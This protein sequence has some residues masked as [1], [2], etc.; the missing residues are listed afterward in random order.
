MNL[1]HLLP[2]AIVLGVQTTLLVIV[3]SWCQ[4]RQ[5]SFQA[6]TSLNVPG[7]IRRMP[8]VFLIT[9]ASILLVSLVA[10][11][12]NGSSFKSPTLPSLLLHIFLRHASVVLLF[13]VFYILVVR[14]YR[15]L[16]KELIITRDLS[17]SRQVWG[18]VLVGSVVIGLKVAILAMSP[19]GFLQ[20]HWR[21]DP[22]LW[23][24]LVNGYPIL[25][26]IDIGLIIG[27]I[28][29][30]EELVFRRYLYT[31]LRDYMST[32]PAVM[33]SIG[34]WMLGHSFT[35]G[36][37]WI[38]VGIFGLVLTLLYERTR[39]I[40]PCIVAHS[41]VNATLVSTL[42]YSFVVRK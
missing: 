10:P 3:A 2:N 28:P 12:L 8:L 30:I 20:Q 15:L 34:C 9:N 37:G 17:L 6:A 21:V 39:S 41:I 29:L 7:Q 24:P 35:G 36:S 31:L 25:T 38:V 5:P 16:W 42:A 4:N 33:I 23:W 32:S 40:L 14:R 22:L 11:P 18:G 13:I 19:P 1:G 27:A 26:F